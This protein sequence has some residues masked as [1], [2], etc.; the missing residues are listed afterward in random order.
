MI[1]NVFYDHDRNRRIETRGAVIRVIHNLDKGC[2]PPT[3]ENGYII[4]KDRGNQTEA[5]FYCHIYYRLEGCKSAMC[6]DNNV[7][8]DLPRCV[9]VYGME[10]RNVNTFFLVLA[11]SL[12]VMYLSNAYVWYKVGKVREL[13]RTKFIDL[14]KL[15]LSS[16]KK[17]ILTEYRMRNEYEYL[18]KEKYN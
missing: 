7:W 11:L 2:D 1:S 12:F 15:K 5:V 9:L 3:L 4:L 17:R 14:K 16:H 13:E 10:E 6:R 8:G 18:G